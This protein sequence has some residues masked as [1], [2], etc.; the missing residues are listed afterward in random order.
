MQCK[1]SFQDLA[2]QQWYKFDN[3]IVTTA[4]IADVRNT[5]GIESR[6]AAGGVE[7]EAPVV[8][9]AYM[10]FYHKGFCDAFLCSSY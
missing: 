5:F 7:V 9:L 6:A 10:L 4:T 8:D 1:N 2:S 3:H